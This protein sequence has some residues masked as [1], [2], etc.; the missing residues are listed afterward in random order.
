MFDKA[1][2]FISEQ[3]LEYFER[4]VG[5]LNPTSA[6]LGL[7]PITGRLGMTVE[8]G[9]KR[10]IFVIG[11]YFNQRLLK[12]VHDWLMSV[13]S[14]IRMDGTFNQQR[15]PLDYL[16]G[17][18]HCYSFDLK[19]ATDGWPLLF[20]FE[21]MQ[22]LFDRSFA[23]SVVNSTLACNIFDVPF[24]K[25]RPSTFSFVAGQPLGDYSSWPLFALSHHLLVWICA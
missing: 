1:N 10:R 22:S 6:D 19:A 16:K 12:P 3:S 23:S 21:V 15:R 7:P 8:G 11:N 18:E 25:K 17:K 13:L 9:G 24:V 20:L 4:F 2:K 14:L 5:P